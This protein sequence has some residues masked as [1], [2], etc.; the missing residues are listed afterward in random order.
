MNFLAHLYL[1]GDSEAIQVGNFIGDYVK[2]R[3]HENYPT[4]IQFGI[5]LHRKIDS[6]TDSHALVRQSALR[7]RPAYRKYAGVVVDMLYDHLLAKNWADY[8]DQTLHAYTQTVY[9]SLFHNWR[10]LPER[11][12][13]FL[14]FM[15]AS[16]RLAS[17]ATIQGIE[18][19]L[20]LMSKYTSLPAQ[21]QTAIQ[22]LESNYAAFD[23]EFN[24]FFE[25]I[26]LF[27]Q[28][29]ISTR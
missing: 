10:H 3:K 16:D 14:P 8:S 25:D 26:K 15:K 11:V 28:T 2:G 1:S 7:L 29:E 6:F 19:S 23:N 12:R 5:L 21:S 22:I 4:D 18:K 17:Y 9:H 13:Y 24:S 27:V 20:Q